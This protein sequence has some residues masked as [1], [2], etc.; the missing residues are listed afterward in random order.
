MSEVNDRG[1]AALSEEWVFAGP[2]GG[3]DV[4]GKAG[5]NGP[6][7]EAAPSCRAAAPT[8]RN[9][10]RQE[11]EDRIRHNKNTPTIRYHKNTR[12]WRTRA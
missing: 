7:P 4:D 1:V 5:G 12:R 10:K 2:R 11:E 9:G 8:G 3:G 6:L